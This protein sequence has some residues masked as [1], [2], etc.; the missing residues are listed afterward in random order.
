VNT[1]E[2]MRLINEDEDFV[3]L[4][5]YWYSLDK[6]VGRYPD[7]APDHVLAAA[8]SIDEDDVKDMYDAIATKLR[9][10]IDAK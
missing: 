7:G 2:V 6:V 10:I 8:L 3:N 9:S 4:K 1:E 5:R